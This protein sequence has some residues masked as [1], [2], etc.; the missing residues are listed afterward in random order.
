[1]VERVRRPGSC[2]SERVSLHSSL[3]THRSRG[4][5]CTWRPFSGS[6]VV[7]SRV[8]GQRDRTPSLHLLPHDRPQCGDDAIDDGSR[9][10]EATWT[11]SAA[12]LWS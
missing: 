2:P 3:L 12:R 4:S 6:Q 1:M 11:A 8:G 5:Q 9:T 7:A 10:F